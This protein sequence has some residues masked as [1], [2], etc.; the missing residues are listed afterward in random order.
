M[1]ISE[2]GLASS[3]AKMVKS[4]DILY[5][6]YGATSG[7][8]GISRIN[9]AINQA[10]LALRP[11]EKYDSNFISQWL[12]SQKQN[13]IAKYLQG[14]QG[15]LS[16]SIVK[17]LNINFPSYKEQVVIGN[18]LNDLNNLITLHQRQY[19]LLQKAKRGFLQ[20]MFPKKDEAEPELRFSGFTDP[21]EQRK[22]SEVTKK[23]R[24]NDGRM[25][26]PTLTISAKNG[27]L[28]QKDRFSGNIAGK[29]Q[30][31]YTLLKRGQLAYNHGNSKL[32]KY[33]AVFALRTYDEALVPRVYHS[34]ETN[35]LA[36]P[37]FIEYMFA[38]KQPDR[39]L[40]KL[41]TS[42][43]RMDGLLNIN[44]DAFMGI[45][46]K[47][48]KLE[49]QIK[50]SQFLRILDHLITLNQRKLD[51]IQKMKKAMLQQMFI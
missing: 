3:S 49:E 14:G 32:A 30:K 13:I 7:E 46:V 31:N 25:D 47:L 37:D 22:L 21:W 34:F 33:G 26:L 20:K 35:E 17:N 24:G 40:G 45:L 16:G 51:T 18:F 23:V 2:N 15:N 8:V 27:W 5:A 29:E 50:I 38:T 1:F 19:D 44:F 39:E 43:A 42:G 4:G 28:N 41:V 48:P 36:D 9:G 6:L 11:N 10:V 12:R